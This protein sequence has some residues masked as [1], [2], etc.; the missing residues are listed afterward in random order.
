[1]NAF[2]EHVPP[3]IFERK[4]G[5]FLAVSGDGSRFKIGVEATTEEEARQRYRKALARWER[6]FEEEPNE[7]HG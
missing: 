7:Q 2:T 5:G 3:R 6:L 1:M 4:C